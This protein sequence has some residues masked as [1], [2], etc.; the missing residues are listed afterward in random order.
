MSGLLGGGRE[1]SMI[2]RREAFMVS[3]LYQS[4]SSRDAIKGRCERKWETPRLLE[5]SLLYLVHVGDAMITVGSSKE[6]RV[7]V[8]WYSLWW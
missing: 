2:L 1:D 4:E 5:G 8:S 6:R 7:V 3:F